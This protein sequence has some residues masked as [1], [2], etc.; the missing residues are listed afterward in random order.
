MRLK[1]KG[2]T[3]FYVVVASLAFIVL[4]IVSIPL[5]IALAQYQQPFPQAILT[6]GGGYHREEFTAQFAKKTVALQIPS[7]TLL[8]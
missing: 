3:K 2:K 6:L 5:K 8:L 7:R 4:L 1:Y